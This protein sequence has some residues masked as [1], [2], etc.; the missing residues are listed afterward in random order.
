LKV[1][2]E[3]IQLNENTLRSGGPV[4]GNINP[5]APKYLHRVSEVLLNEEV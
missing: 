1:N 2:E 5:D 4:P 3:L